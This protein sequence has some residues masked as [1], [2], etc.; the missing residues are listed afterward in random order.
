MFIFTIR[1]EG[2]LGNMY[3]GKVLAFFAK[4]ENLDKKGIIS[5]KKNW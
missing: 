5:K 1:L 3:M 4:P 2:A